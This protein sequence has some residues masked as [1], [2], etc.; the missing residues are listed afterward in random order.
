[1][2]IIKADQ[3]KAIDSVLLILF[4]YFF[5]VSWTPSNDYETF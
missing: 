3:M 1:M 2:Q 4:V 5:S